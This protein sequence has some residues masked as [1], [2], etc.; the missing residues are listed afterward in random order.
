MLHPGVLIH[1][2]LHVLGGRSRGFIENFTQCLLLPLVDFL[3]L[4]EAR[5]F[6]DFVLLIELPAHHRHA[7]L[8]VKQ[9]GRNGRPLHIALEL[10]VSLL[11]F[12]VL[13]GFGYGRPVSEVLQ[14]AGLP[15]VP[16]Y[17]ALPWTCR[18]VHFITI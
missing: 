4:L 18:T 6:G 16:D 10:R 3:E 11:E 15:L 2:G 1:L 9:S 13:R 12:E 5:G 14:L 17:F 8:F 7:V